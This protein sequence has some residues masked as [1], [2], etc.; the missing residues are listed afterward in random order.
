MRSST[1]VTSTYGKKGHD[2]TQA[3]NADGKNGAH[4]SQASMNIGTASGDRAV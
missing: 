1:H 2:G 4:P 3:K